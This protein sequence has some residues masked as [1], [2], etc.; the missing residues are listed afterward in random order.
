[1]LFYSAI[2]NGVVA[3]PWMIL[4]MLW[5]NNRRGWEGSRIRERLN[6]S[7]GSQRH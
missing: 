7:D 3:P 4:I 5:P 2:L 6:V 1:M